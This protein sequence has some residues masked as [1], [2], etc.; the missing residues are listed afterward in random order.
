MVDAKVV[1]QES[2]DIDLLS[3]DDPF[4]VS[5]ERDEKVMR[6]VDQER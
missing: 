4:G 1:A 2:F 5:V 6:L 3:R